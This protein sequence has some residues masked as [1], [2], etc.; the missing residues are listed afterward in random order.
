MR[1]QE[2]GDVWLDEALVTCSCGG[3]LLVHDRRG[4]E[5]VLR[6]TRCRRC[7]SEQRVT[8]RPPETAEERVARMMREAR[9]C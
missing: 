2:L 8:V 9:G 5:G 7:G 6:V 3:A 4:A 1:Q